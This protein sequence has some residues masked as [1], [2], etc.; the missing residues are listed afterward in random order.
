[1]HECKHFY[2]DADIQIDT[3]G[4]SVE[5]TA[6]KILRSLDRFLA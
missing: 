5:D 6:M 4:K 2:A 1:M 3:D